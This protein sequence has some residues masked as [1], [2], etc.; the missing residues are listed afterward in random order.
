MSMLLFRWCWC[1]RCCWCCNAVNVDVD[2]DAYIVVDVVDV[3]DFVDVANVIVVV[4]VDVDIDTD[5]D[6]ANFDVDV[7]V[8]LIVDSKIDAIVVV[9]EDEDVADVIVGVVDA[10]S[11]VVGDVDVDPMGGIHQR[12]LNE[13]FSPMKIF[14]SEFETT[15]TQTR[16]KEELNWKGRWSFFCSHYS[17]T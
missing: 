16:K 1:Y 7:V 6:V 12:W 17:A 3:F 5:T 13:L 14:A 8:D 2:V 10:G 4:G 15:L 9:G 11:D